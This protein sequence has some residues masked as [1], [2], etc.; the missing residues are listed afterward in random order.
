MSCLTPSPVYEPSNRRGIKLASSDS[1]GYTIGIDWNIAFPES[2]NYSIAY[3]IYYSTL[4]DHVF[5]EGVKAVSVDPEIITGHLIDNFR[6]GDLFYFSVRAFEYL[7]DY[8]N[9][10]LLPNSVSPGFKVY[11]EG[12][13]LSDIS[14]SDTSIPISDIDSFP[15]YGIIQVGYEF[16]QY[17]SKDIPSSS[18]LV[19]SGTRGFSN[20]T[21][22]LHTVDGYDG[23]DFRDPIVKFWKGYEDDNTVIAQATSNFHYPNFPYTTADGYKT[24][25]KDILTTDLTENEEIQDNFPT[26]DYAGYHMTSPAD[27]LSGKCLNT[28][29]FGVQGCSDGYNV[30]GQT[31]GIPLNEQNSQRLEILL[32]VRGEPVT[33]VRRLWTG[34][35]C[36]CYQSEVENPNLRCQYCYGTGFITGY[37]QYFNP[38]RSDGRILMS[39]SPSEETFPITDS[40]L[41]YTIPVDTWMLPVPSVHA[42]DFIIRYQAAGGLEDSRFEITSVTRNDIFQSIKGAQRLK[43]TRLRRTDPTYQW[44][45]IKSTAN[46]PITLT[47]GIGLMN[48]GGTLQPHTHT[49][50]ISGDMVLSVTQIN[51]TT[52]ES[53]FHNHE[54][55]NGIVLANGLDH[56]HSLT[57]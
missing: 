42:R 33:L 52:S 11:P 2:P 57:L 15:S 28:Y 9:L 26:Y 49:I 4:L 25:D 30:G 34:T 39:F 13:L 20:T 56:T 38:K 5:S 53:Q 43:L 35:R 16:I 32:S 14:D 19:G 1:D 29:I 41:E 18:L 8:Y 27:L 50:T 55:R 7:P 3:N 54:I 12:M 23:V 17:S 48:I 36:A 24:V 46:I 6:P 47:T 51:G 40:G 22:R 10:N 45:S 31:K 44:K 21:A 37:E